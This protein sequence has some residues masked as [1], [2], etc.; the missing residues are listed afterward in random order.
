VT[1]DPK[2]L[3][4]TAVKTFGDEFDTLSLWSGT[5]G[6]WNTNY[7]WAGQSG[8]TLD[9]NGEEEWYINHLYGPT[10][11]VTPWT[12]SN[13]ILTLTADHADPAIQPL[14]NNYQYTS[15][16]IQSY[17][18]FSQLYGYF[19][20]RAKMPSG[21]GL[22]PAF[23][24]LPVDG[25]WPPEIDV[26]EVLGHDTTTL[27]NAVHYNAPRHKSVG[28]ATQFR[29]ANNQL[30]DLSADFHT[31]GVDWQADYITWYFDGEQV[32]QT[33]TPPGVNKP[34]YILANLAV[35]G[36]WPG[37]PDASTQFPAEYQIDYIR[38]YQ[39]DG[40]PDPVPPQE[41][42]FTLPASKPWTYEVP[43]NRIG[44]GDTLVGTSGPDLLDGN[45]YLLDGSYVKEATPEM[46]MLKGGGGDDTYR[47]DRS[48]DKVY[49]NA[50]SGIDTVESTAASYKLPD[51][52][53]NLTLIGSSAQTAT[54]NALNNILTSNDFGS[55]LSGGDGKDILIAG[56]R[57]DTLTGGTGTDI[58]RFDKIPSTS[59][60]LTDFVIGDMLDL[61]GLFASVG[62]SGGDPGD[63]VHFT[64][65]T[66]GTQVWFDADGGGAG[67]AKL[68][69]TLDNF[70][71]ALR[72][73]TDWFYQ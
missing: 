47:I 7:W 71:V 11:S 16:Q 32:F 68:V 37:S 62:Y 50:N 12:V 61:R 5:S 59:G 1:I 43:G 33:A 10:S 70:H 22:W 40:I 14:I 64:D 20:I 39:D 30:I 58:F 31:Y 29:D 73:Q 51:N 56:L 9:G 6:T 27:H 41:L 54:G 19:E 52:V 34:M 67:L 44:R 13:G 38:V 17:Y 25:S 4:G 3:Q 35:G 26:L 15:G 23:W 60:H 42:L 48:T 2:N 8:S 63:Y 72:V 21:Q 18:S 49:E 24:L 66:G 36:S 57:A 65:T 55:K 69:T 45:G 46:D 53:E 28:A